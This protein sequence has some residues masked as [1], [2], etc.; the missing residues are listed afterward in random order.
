[1]FVEKFVDIQPVKKYFHLPIDFAC[2]LT[3][4]AAV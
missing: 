1:M 3:I 4:F 2:F